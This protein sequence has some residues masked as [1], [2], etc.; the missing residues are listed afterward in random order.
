MVGTWQVSSFSRT[1]PQVNQLSEASLDQKTKP[2]VRWRLSQEENQCGHVYNN[3]NPIPLLEKPQI[4]QITLHKGLQQRV[5]YMLYTPREHYWLLESTGPRP[6]RDS[7][8][9]GLQAPLVGPG[10][11]LVQA[12]IS[13]SHWVRVHHKTAVLGRRKVNRALE[14]GCVPFSF[15]ANHLNMAFAFLEASVYKLVM[16]RNKS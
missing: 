8:P 4:H 16:K 14:L 13:A 10:P 1:E 11:S 7:Q 12:E 2:I 15:Q 5:G 9:E 3:A 6:T